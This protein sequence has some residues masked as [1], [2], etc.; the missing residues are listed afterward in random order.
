MASL[1]HHMTVIRYYRDGRDWDAERVMSPKWSDVEAAVRRMDNYCFP[2]VQLNT[3]DDDDDANE[4]V[5]GVVGGAGRWALRQMNGYWEYE[6]PT[7]DD[8][9][10]VA[11]WESD[12]GYFCQGRNI[13]TD[14]EKVVRIVKAYYDTGSYAALDSVE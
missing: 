13:L 11:L 6:D 2:C 5:F 4:S 8:E 7:S 10:E 14:V 12:Q 1:I 9:E 3:T